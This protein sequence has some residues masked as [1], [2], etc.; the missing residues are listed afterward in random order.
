MSAGDWLRWFHVKHFASARLVVATAPRFSRVP[1]LG[2]TT[3]T[4]QQHARKDG[5]CSVLCSVAVRPL[6]HECLADG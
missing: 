5:Y 3:S 6:P 4:D 1:V 2:A